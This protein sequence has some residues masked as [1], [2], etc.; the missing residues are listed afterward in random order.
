MMYERIKTYIS[1]YSWIYYICAAVLIL[2]FG[3]FIFDGG[4]DSDYQR[5]VE[6][7]ER[8][9]DE[10]RNSLELNQAVKTSIERSAQLNQQASERISRAQEYQQQAITRIDESASRLD[11]AE[12]LLTRNEQLI[13][14]VEQGYQA[15][16]P[17]GTAT[18]QTA[19][20]VGNN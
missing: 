10:Q 1:R 2:L 11:E 9:K 12:K 14:R 19:Q 8:S 20:H 7:M 4:N 17:N 3:R 5:A 15:K 18:A 13:E 16:S 6:H